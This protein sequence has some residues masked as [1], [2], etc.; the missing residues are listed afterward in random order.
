MK[1]K[2]TRRFDIQL[3]A[4]TVVSYD[5][6]VYQVPGD[7]P[8]DHADRAMQQRIG[9]YLMTVKKTPENKLAATPENKAGMGRKTKRRRRTRTKPDA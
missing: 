6:G 7:M 1:F 5:S 2:L 3:D 9:R 4:R 8:K